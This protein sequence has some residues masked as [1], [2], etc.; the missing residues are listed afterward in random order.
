M[1]DDCPLCKESKLNVGDKTDYGSVIIFKLGNE[2]NGWFA[3]LSPKT[4]GDPEKDFTV[5]L[6]PLLHLNHMSEISN[7][8]DLAKNY[9]IAFSQISKSIKEIMEKEGRHNENEEGVIRIGTYGKSK[10]LNEHFHIKI[11]PW[12]GK[13]GQP[14]TVDTTFEK[15]KIHLGEDGKEFIKLEPVRKIK[16][17]EARLNDLSNKFISRLKWEK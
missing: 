9:G 11:F 16:I 10:H 14:Y 15:S 2:N 12:T 4:G 1:I 7:N 3:T 6:M 17:N 13:I 8:I 5:Q